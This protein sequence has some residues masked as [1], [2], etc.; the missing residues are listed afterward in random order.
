MVLTQK[1][2]GL[3]KDLRTQEQLCIEKYN[4]YACLACDPNLK[5]LFMS[6]KDTEKKHLNTVN[7]MLGTDQNAE[8]Q[9]SSFACDDP[10]STQA[11]PADVDKKKYDA[12]LCQDIL[13][14]EKHVS[15]LY[16]LSIFEFADPAARNAL[17]E[18]QKDE[19]HHGE[20]IYNYMSK[21]GLY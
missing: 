16:D 19:Q 4:K 9:F 11:C 15:S 20:Q 13:A 12:Y 18:I 3:L 2:S 10:H 5:D 7:Q 8:A 17:N 14:T 1:E 21:N 6:I